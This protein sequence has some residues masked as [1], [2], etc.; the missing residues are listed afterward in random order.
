MGEE[1]SLD[2]ELGDLLVV[3]WATDQTEDL[4]G[5]FGK[6]HRALLLVSLSGNSQCR[7]QR[8]VALG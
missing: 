2:R 4:H 7:A 5:S 8:D 1:I 6:R 3:E